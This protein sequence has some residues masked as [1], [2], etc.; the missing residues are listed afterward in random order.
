MTQGAAG[1]STIHCPEG[2]STMPYISETWHGTK[3]K[4]HALNTSQHAA[5][6]PDLAEQTERIELHC[7]KFGAPGGDWCEYLAFDETG[8]LL[9]TRHINGY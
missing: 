3:A 8:T 7:S 1:S 2:S 4:E 9:R 5:N 6:M